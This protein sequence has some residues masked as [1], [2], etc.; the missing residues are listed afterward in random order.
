MAKVSQGLFIITTMESEILDQA[1]ELLEKANAKLEPE[2]LTAPDARKL[3]AAYAR[4][5]KLAAFGVAALARKLDNASALA[6]VTGTSV[7]KAK[8]VVDTARVL[9][10]SADLSSA[11]QRGAISLDQA[12][13]IAKAEQSSPGAAAELVDVAQKESFHV[14]KDRARATKLEAE[15]HNGLAARQRAARFAHSHSDELGMVHIDLALEPHVG[16][17]IVNRAEAEADRLNK[18]ARAKGEAE[19]FE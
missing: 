4:A 2:L 13:E 17:P 6:R 7:G 15:Q 11:L 18:K 10:H 16:T 14:L 9:G 12:S 5:E 19:P 3:L 1:T 8:V